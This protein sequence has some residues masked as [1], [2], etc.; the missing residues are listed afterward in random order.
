[1]RK[2][3]SVDDSALIQKRLFYFSHFFHGCGLAKSQ[4]LPLV[5][6]QGQKL[7]FECNRSSGSCFVPEFSISRSGS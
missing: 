5:D 2:I 4:S 7:Y 1:M 3:H 6:S